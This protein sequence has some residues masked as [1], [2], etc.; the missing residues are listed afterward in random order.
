MGRWSGVT[1]GTYILD[2]TTVMTV[3]P[4]QKKGLSDEETNLMDVEIQILS[5][6]VGC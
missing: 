4:I 1:D 6:D 3:I 2:V 5:V